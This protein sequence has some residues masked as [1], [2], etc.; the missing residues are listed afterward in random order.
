MTLPISSKGKKHLISVTA[1]DRDSVH[2]DC[3]LH[4]LHLNI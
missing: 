3:K 4:N 1:E 2:E